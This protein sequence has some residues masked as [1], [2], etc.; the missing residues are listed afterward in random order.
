MY[1]K[2]LME[3]L[4]CDDVDPAV[5]H[6]PGARPSGVYVCITPNRLGGPHDISRNFDDVA[7][8]FTSGVHDSGTGAPVQGGRLLA[9]QISWARAALHPPSARPITHE[10]VLESFR[11]VA[12]PVARSLPFW[13]L[14]GVRLV[15]TK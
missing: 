7:T 9:N 4:H 2:E 6:L 5:E 10:A 3:H 11:A 8:G 14:L 1:S 15:A 13:A 12:R